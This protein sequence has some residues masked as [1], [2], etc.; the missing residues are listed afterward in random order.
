MRITS[1]EAIPVTARL[2]RPFRFAGVERVESQNVVV[3]VRT[4]EGFT[5]YGEACPVPH[6]SA[7][8]QQ[9]IVRVVEDLATPI[10][11]GEDPRAFRPLLARLERAIVNDPFSLAAL[12]TAIL[13]AT[14]KSIGVSIAELLGGAFRQ[15][16]PV[17]AS[18]SWSSDGAEMI[19]E[20]MGLIDQYTY[21][22]VYVGRGDLKE[23]LARLAGL[24]DAVGD[25][26]ELMLDVNGQWT[27]TQT[28]KAL[29]TLEAM[30][31]AAIEQPVSPHDIPGQQR[32]V[33][34][35]TI[36]IVVDEGIRRPGDAAAAGSAAI[37]TVANVGV[38]KLGGILAAYAA[39]T[40]AYASGLRVTVG[41]LAEL[42]IAN[43]GGLQLAAALPV[44]AYPS[45]LTGYKRY[46]E[47]ITGPLPV[48]DGGFIDVPSHPGIGVDVD[49]DAIRHM[50]ARIG[51]R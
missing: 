2:S 51:H 25:K 34:T 21:L 14:S 30:G 42:G 13:D 46:A 43:A 45:Y 40:V 12:D 24:R 48:N 3:I 49:E 11:V 36:D 10:V 6:L 31:I 17:H 35:S 16:V 1:V 28:L 19:D 44:L 22:K 7:A 39:A 15:T 9:A 38:S 18:V 50:D 32:V 23:D 4:D 27:A 20:A 47:Q 26:P 8:G 37:G 5:G 29:P 33:Q 41:S